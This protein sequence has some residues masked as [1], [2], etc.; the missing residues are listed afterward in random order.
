[1][2]KN[3]VQV[4]KEFK[5]CRSKDEYASVVN[6]VAGHNSGDKLDRFFMTNDLRELQERI[7]V[8]Q[9]VMGQH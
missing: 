7:R 2:M 6:G 9:V 8:N 4:G 3:K 5:R 1:M